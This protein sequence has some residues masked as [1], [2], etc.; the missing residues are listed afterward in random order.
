MRRRPAP[1]VDPQEGD[2]APG[3]AVGLKAPPTEGREVGSRFRFD[4]A[5]GKERDTTVLMDL[6]CIFMEE[7][8]EPI[9]F[10]FY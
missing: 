4:A 10:P 1:H 7:N 6:C 8:G 3:V 9:G 2:C 5:K